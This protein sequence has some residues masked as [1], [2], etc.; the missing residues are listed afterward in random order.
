MWHVR[1]T[2]SAI[3]I[4]RPRKRNVLIKAPRVRLGGTGV[5]DELLEIAYR[6]C[7]PRNETVKLAKQVLSLKRQYPSG[8]LPE[9]LVYIQLQADQEEFLF[10]TDFEQGRSYRG[11]SVV[12]FF[13]PARNRLI[14]VMGNYFHTLPGKQEEDEVQKQALLGSMINGSRVND[15]VDLWESKI[16]DCHRERWIRLAVQGIEVGR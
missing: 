10:Q 14:R 8:T 3:K 5:S 7:G 9:L 4:K 16:Y 2:V 6:I 11:G 12:D 1:N 15:V 13:L